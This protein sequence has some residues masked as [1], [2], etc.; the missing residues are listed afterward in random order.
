MSKKITTCP[1]FFCFQHFPWQR[2]RWLQVWRFSFFFYFLALQ[3]LKPILKSKFYTLRNLKMKCVSLTINDSDYG[4]MVQSKHCLVYVY[5]TTKRCAFGVWKCPSS[6][7]IV[8]F[9]SKKVCSTCHVYKLSFF[10]QLYRILI[11]DPRSA[12]HGEIFTSKPSMVISFKW[13][14]HATM[15]WQ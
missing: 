3:Y 6:P 14:T 13:Q 9:C 2:C 5:A 1:V 12:V 7:S 4:S 11:I 10:I 8:Y 15:L